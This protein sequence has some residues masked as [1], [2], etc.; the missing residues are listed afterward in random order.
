[1]KSGEDGA[2]QG[3]DSKQGTPS[4]R[5]SV[6]LARMNKWKNSAERNRNRPSDLNVGSN[7]N[8]QSQER[9]LSDGRNS[10]GRASQ[11]SIRRASVGKPSPNVNIVSQ[12]IRPSVRTVV[13]KDSN[14]GHQQQ[15][16]AGPSTGSL[17]KSQMIAGGGGPHR[18]ST[19]RNN[20]GSVVQRG[21][22]MPLKP[23]R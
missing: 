4:K 2:S 20:A 5:M 9:Q 12:N 14:A 1:M 7:S 21:T 6:T 23:S 11:T 10:F 15:Q 22:T 13:R 8:D 17:A 3:G 19:L 18:A 16:S